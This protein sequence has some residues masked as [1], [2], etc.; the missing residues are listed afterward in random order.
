MTMA[1][2]NHIFEW[3]LIVNIILIINYYRINLIVVSCKL[4]ECLPLTMR[5]K[6][7]LMHLYIRF[8]RFRGL[9]ILNNILQLD[10]GA[11]LNHSPTRSSFPCKDQFLAKPVTGG[12]G[13][14]ILLQDEPYKFNSGLQP[15]AVLWTIYH[16]DNI[17][18]IL[19]YYY[20]IY[21]Y[22]TITIS[23]RDHQ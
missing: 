9:H 17:I 22:I 19:L 2:S 11:R 4:G 7:F 23:F 15:K 20:C 10:F 8:V 21:K 6:T 16:Y 18:V 5:G 3:Q 1:S 13:G 12:H 14:Q